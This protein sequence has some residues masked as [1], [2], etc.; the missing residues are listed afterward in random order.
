MVRGLFRGVDTP[1]ESA[2]YNVPSAT[3][4]APSPWCFVTAKNWGCCRSHVR[5]NVSET[6]DGPHALA[7]VAPQDQAVTKH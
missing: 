2:S 5:Q 1:L 6:L 7:S 4:Q 3:S